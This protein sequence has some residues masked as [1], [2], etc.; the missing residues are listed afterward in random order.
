MVSTLAVASVAKSLIRAVASFQSY[1]SAI[2]SKLLRSSPIFA[3]QRV[4]CEGRPFPLPPPLPPF[5]QVVSWLEPQ[6]GDPL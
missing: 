5:P 1:F 4:L 6:P 2:L 3:L